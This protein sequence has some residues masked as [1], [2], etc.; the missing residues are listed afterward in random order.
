VARLLVQ[1]GHEVIVAN[2]SKVRA[3]SA[4]LRKTDQ[5]DARCLAQLGRVDPE[6]LAPVH[7]RSEEAQK[8]LA[9]VRSREVWCARTQLINQV[10]GSVK[11]FGARL[12]ASSTASFARKVQ[13]ACRPS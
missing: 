11:A 2:P 10:R 1:L 9:V 13:E 6:L 4:S 5:R 3:I 8:V 7:P 12:P